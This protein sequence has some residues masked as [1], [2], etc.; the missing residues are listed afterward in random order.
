MR[1]FTIELF[2]VIVVC[3]QGLPEDERDRPLEVRYGAGVQLAIWRCR[4]EA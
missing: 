1:G 3:F 2:V 4:K